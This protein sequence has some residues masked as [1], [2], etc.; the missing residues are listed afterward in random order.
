MEGKKD[1]NKGEGVDNELIYALIPLMVS[2]DK[3]R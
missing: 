1:T 2:M 3:Q